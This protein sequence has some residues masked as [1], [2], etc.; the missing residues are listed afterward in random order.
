MQ[1]ASWVFLLTSHV[2]WSRKCLQPGI[3][4]EHRPKKGKREGK[5]P[6]WPEHQESRRFPHTP[7]S[8]HGLSPPVAPCQ[9]SSQGPTCGPLCSHDPAAEHWRRSTPPTRRVRHRPSALWPSARLWEGPRCASSRALGR[10]SRRPARWVLPALGSASR[11]DLEGSRRTGRE[12]LGVLRVSQHHLGRPPA[13]GGT[14][15]LCICARGGRVTASWSLKNAAGQNCLAGARGT[16]L[17]LKLQLE[18]VC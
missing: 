15:C 4:K 1:R 16:K 7:G 12:R 11:R 13:P 18:P 14:F 2:S 8:S 5:P 9:Q 6:A 3:A 10:S 17:S